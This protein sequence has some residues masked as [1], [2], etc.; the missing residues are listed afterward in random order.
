[1]EVVTDTNVPMWGNYMYISDT[2]FVSHFIS[3]SVINNQIITEK[4][5]M[6]TDKLCVFTLFQVLWKSYPQSAQWKHNNTIS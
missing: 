4:V 3:K 6:K 5:Y 1:M 2:G